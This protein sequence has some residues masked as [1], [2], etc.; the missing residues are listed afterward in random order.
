M[1]SFDDWRGLS[2]RIHSECLD[3]RCRMTREALEA[4]LLRLPTEERAH[5]ARVL[6]ESLDDEPD[7]DGAWLDEAR[8]RA[9]ELKSGTSQGIPA[10]AA[11]ANA[12]RRLVG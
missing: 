6:I 1:N 2:R 12:R 4:E 10:D 5:L 11:F 7:V 3:T 8:R 9:D